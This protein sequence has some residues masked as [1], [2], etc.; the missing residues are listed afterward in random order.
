MQ[1]VCIMDSIITYCVSIACMDAGCDV[2]RQRCTRGPAASQQCG[3]SFQARSLQHP[4]LCTSAA[5]TKQ[6]KE[7]QLESAGVAIAQPIVFM[8]A[9]I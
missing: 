6:F 1:H 5:C 8:Q 7:R 9:L 4:K 3:P 2:A